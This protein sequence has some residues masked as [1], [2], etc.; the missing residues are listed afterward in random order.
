VYAS[1]GEIFV[2]VAPVGPAGEGDDDDIDMDTVEVAGGPLP[3]MAG[4]WPGLL[5][6][7]AGVLYSSTPYMMSSGFSQLQSHHG[8]VSVCMGRWTH[9]L[10]RPTTHR[11]PG[12]ARRDHAC[13]HAYGPCTRARREHRCS[14]GLTGFYAPATQRNTRMIMIFL[15]CLWVRVSVY[16]RTV[17]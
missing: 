9:Q 16:A 8:F 11:H 1:G 12:R 10:Q 14:G 3:C 13:M 6:N 15:A 4:A 17:T 2:R 5:N 7:A